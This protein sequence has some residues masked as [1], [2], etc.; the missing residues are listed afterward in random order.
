[1][2]GPLVLLKNINVTHYVT[3][4]V[5][6]WALATWQSIVEGSLGDAMNELHSLVKLLESLEGFL[7][8]YEQNLPSGLRNPFYKPNLTDV[9]TFTSNLVSAPT[10]VLCCWYCCRG[11]RCRE[12]EDSFEIFIRPIVSKWVAF[13]NVLWRITLAVLPAIA[14]RHSICSAQ[15]SSRV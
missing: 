11:L 14:Q 4:L 3:L 6:L 2:I 13:F 12:A 9:L 5:Q 8:R 7:E 1:M 10:R 15:S